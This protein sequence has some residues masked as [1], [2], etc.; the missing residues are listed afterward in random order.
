MRVDMG[1]NAQ[2]DFNPDFTELLPGGDD[3]PFAANLTGFSNTQPTPQSRVTADV[4]LPG[5]FI[6]ANGITFS[7]DL[8]IRTANVPGQFQGF[9]FVS[10]PLDVTG[11]S[12]QLLALTARVSFFDVVLDE[13]FTSALTPTGNPY[14]WLWSGLANVTLTGELVP[15]VTVPTV[16]PVE[17]EPVPFSQ[18]LT[19]PLAGTF[20]GIPTG[21]EITVGIPIDTLENQDL[22]LPTIE[23]QFDVAELGVVTGFFKL[24]TLLLTDFSTEA[25]YRN[26]TPLPEP[27]T[28]PL[29]A[30]AIAGAAL[31]QRRR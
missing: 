3:F 26:A 20:S 19:I 21:T 23:Q 8:L 15:M 4:G 31:Y 7:P 12:F 1:V 25:V 6:E 14:E 24:D 30:L 9:G 16:P 29:V 18:S 11:A 2:V 5:N 10:V 17:L 28:G 13:P 22:S 27:S